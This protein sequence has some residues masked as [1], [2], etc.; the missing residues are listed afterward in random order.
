MSRTP[1]DE[2][3]HGASGY[4]NH[5]CRCETCKKGNA[6][7]AASSRERLKTELQERNGTAVHPRAPHG[8]VTGY[9]NYSCRCFPCRKA[10]YDSK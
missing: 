6:E 2:F 3:E 9:I 4:T 10:A 7:R 5:K 1:S 8:T